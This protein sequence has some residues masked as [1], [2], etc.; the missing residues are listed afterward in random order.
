MIKA[1]GNSTA[2]PHAKRGAGPIEVGVKVFCV[3]SPALCILSTNKT[4]KP[5]KRQF[6]QNADVQRRPAAFQS[7]VQVNQH[8]LSTSMRSRAIQLHRFDLVLDA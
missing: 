5:L 4:S 2:H 7:V 6:V 3:I 1:D 8:T